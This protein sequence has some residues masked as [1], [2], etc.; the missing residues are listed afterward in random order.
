MDLPIEWRHDI[1]NF[2]KDPSG[3]QGTPFREIRLDNPMPWQDIHKEAIELKNKLIPMAPHTNHHK[4]MGVSF[5][6][7]N[8]H[9]LRPGNMD[10]CTWTEIAN[11]CPITVDW[12]KQLPFYKRFGR[13]CFAWVFS[14]GWIQPHTD[15]KNEGLI[16]INFGVYNPDGSHMLM[17]PGLYVPWRNGSA[18][19]LDLSFKHAV[20][21]R[22]NEGRL[23][24]ICEGELH[25]I[26][27]YLMDQPTM[28]NPNNE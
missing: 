17:E 5:H 11:K 21:N 18:F 14:K 16:G 4:W 10:Q 9:T 2:F 3:K 26:S 23:H 19:Q 6:G 24:I 8:H 28:F 25:D 13:I 1:R 22:S 15:R 27:K 20:I 12:F 7:I